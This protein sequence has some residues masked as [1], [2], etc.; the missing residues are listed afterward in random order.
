MVDKLVVESTKSLDNNYPFLFLLAELSLSSEFITPFNPA[1]V[2][3]IRYYANQHGELVPIIAGSMPLPIYNHIYLFGVNIDGRLHPIFD[4]R[5]RWILVNYHTGQ[6]VIV[7]RAF[8][9]TYG[10]RYPAEIISQLENHNN[11][12]FV[13]PIRPRTGSPNLPADGRRVHI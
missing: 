1:N 9:H 3:D 6:T 8:Y 4:N 2:P 7:T 13:M 10:H 5:R 11:L 12:E